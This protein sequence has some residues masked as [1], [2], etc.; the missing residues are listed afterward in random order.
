MTGH[1]FLKVFF[2]ILYNNYPGKISSIWIIK[3]LNSMNLLKTQNKP[4]LGAPLKTCYIRREKSMFF[5]Y[6]KILLKNCSKNYHTNKKWKIK[7]DNK[8]KQKIWGK[9]GL[10]NSPDDYFTRPKELSNH[11]NNRLWQIGDYFFEKKIKK[12]SF[13]QF[14]GDLWGTK[15]VLI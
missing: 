12:I 15:T 8:T 9:K 1:F 6:L 13:K 11:V 10:K 3:K 4:L 14:W 5:P 2:K 7:K